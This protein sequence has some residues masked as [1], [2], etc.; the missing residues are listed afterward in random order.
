MKHL[1]IMPRFGQSA[2]D[3]Y[4]FPLGIAYLSSMLK[5]AGYEVYNLNLNNSDTSIK[6][7]V[8]ESILKHDI[9]I[10]AVGGLS[11]HFTQI[12]TICDTAKKVKPRIVTI[13]GGGLLTATPELVLGGI[14]SA[15]IGIIGEG[16]R[17]I[18]E[19]AES[20][21]AGCGDFQNINGIVYRKAT[22]ICKT[23]PRK[24][25]QNLD[26]LPF[27]DYDGFLFDSKRSFMSI[28]TSRSCPFSCTFCFHTCGKTYRT[29]SIDNIFAEIDW[30]C[31]KYNIK[32]IGVLDE[33]F[34]IDQMSAF[35]ERIAP[36]NLSWS[37]QLRADRIDLD[38]LKLMKKAG[39]S[40]ISLGIESADDRILRS[41]RKKITITQIEYALRVFKEAKIHPMGNLLFGDKNDDME[42]FITNLR[43]YKDHYDLN[44][45]FIRT[46]ILPGT[47]LYAH[48]VRERYITDEIQYLEDGHFT[49]NIT[50]LNNKEYNK[51]LSMMD[52]AVLYHEFPAENIEIIDI[53]KDRCHI[54]IRCTCPLCKEQI[55][56]SMKNF[57][58]LE[59]FSCNNCGQNINIHLFHLLQNI[60]EPEIENIL[61]SGKIVIWGMGTVGKKFASSCRLIGHENLFLIDRD[62]KMYG[63]EFGGKAVLGPD[64]FTFDASH[65]LFGTS[66]MG[67]AG[68]AISNTTVIQT[69]KDTIANMSVQVNNMLELDAFLFAI[70]ANAQ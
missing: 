36:Y 15:D 40:V 39:C 42:S 43:W 3:P 25:I 7:I 9:D 26:E 34:S 67:K 28:C 1:L 57:F 18:I 29:R 27:P 51:C 46:L 38:T 37:C 45:G 47:E 17:T 65:V 10:V 20:L 31:G 68:T 58:A 55:H 52:D 12:R 24:D 56:A 48:S 23:H 21:E 22:E 60:L 5:K 16:E 70:L 13:V 69:I 30:L 53:N 8:A 19:L 63:K 41:M 61:R 6:D 33:L 49:I 54:N 44:L 62:P 14:T 66:L 11:P 50:K 32:T 4:I 64:C 2:N 59:N 35:C